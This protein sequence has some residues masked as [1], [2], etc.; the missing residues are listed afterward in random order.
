MQTAS[1]GQ[2]PVHDDIYPLI[3]ANDTSAIPIERQWGNL[4]PAYSVN[5]SVYGLNSASGLVPDQCE[6]TQ[7]ILYFRHGARYPTTGAPPSAFAAK[8]QAASQNGTGLTA[9]GDLDF[10]SSWQYKLGAELL[11]PFGRKQ[12]FDWGVAARVLY[13]HLLQN[14][15]EAGTLPVFRTQSQDRMVKTMLNFAGGFF[16]IPDYATD[17]NLEIVVEAEN[18][19]NTGAPYDVCPNSNNARGSVGT[20]AATAF[21][22][23]YYNQ[24]AERLNQNLQGL[25]LNATDINAMLQLCAYEVRGRQWLISASYVSAVADT[26]PA[27]RL[28]PLAIRNSAVCSRSKTSRCLSKLSTSR[29][30]ATKVSPRL[31]ALRKDSATF[32]S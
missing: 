31:S 8:L 3:V 12:N 21:A 19:N 23:P 22:A 7:V 1:A 18:Y 9:T 29:S 20:A 24:T 6:I 26:G 28:L 5:S 13:G 30:M 2:Y 15:T 4:S 17:F 14:F 11:T 27:N 25:T 32:K 10:L 16:G